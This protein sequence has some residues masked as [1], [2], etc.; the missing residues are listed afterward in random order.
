ME[1][2]TC[3]AQ[4]ADLNKHKNWHSHI[5]LGVQ[6][7]NCNLRKLTDAMQDIRKLVDKKVRNEEV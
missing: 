2:E 5:L 7:F 3:G 4:V 6:A 1:C